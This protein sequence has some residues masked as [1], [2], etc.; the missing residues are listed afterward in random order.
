MPGDTEVLLRLTGPTSSDF[1]GTLSPDG[2]GARLEAALPAGEL[3]G[4][5]RQVTLCPAP[6]A[7][8]RRYLPLPVAVRAGAGGVQAVHPSGPSVVLRLARRVRRVLGGVRATA[9]RVR[10]RRN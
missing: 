1:P 10:A 7:D 5:A 9:A 2:S 8:E 3:T 6:K 4:A